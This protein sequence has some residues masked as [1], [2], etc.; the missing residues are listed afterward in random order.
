MNS[1]TSEMISELTKQYLDKGGVITIVEPEEE[2]S[3]FILLGVDE[4]D[5][6]TVQ[7]ILEKENNNP[8]V[9]NDYLYKNRKSA[10][11]FKSNW[12]LH[13]YNGYYSGIE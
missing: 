13:G 11:K 6:Q 2:V 3:K 4:E 9:M 10:N 5:Y 8:D 1:I 12:G 7:V